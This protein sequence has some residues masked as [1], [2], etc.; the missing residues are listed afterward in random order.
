VPASDSGNPRAR[1]FFHRDDEDD[2]D[3]GKQRGERLWNSI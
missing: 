3:E 2:D 1:V